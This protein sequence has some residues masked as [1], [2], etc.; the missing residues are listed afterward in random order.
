MG[1]GGRQRI[2]KGI[3]GCRILNEEVGKVLIKKVKGE[4]QKEGEGKITKRMSKS[5]RV[6]KLTFTLKVPT[7]HK[8]LY[9]VLHL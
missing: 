1:E 2:E 7:I 4:M 3:V 9:I 6:I 8:S 5:H